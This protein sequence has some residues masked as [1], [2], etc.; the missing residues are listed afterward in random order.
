MLARFSV[1]AQRESS[2]SFAEQLLDALLVLARLVDLGRVLL[3]L[4][5]DDIYLRD[6]FFG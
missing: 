6:N 2:V 3:L 4:P 5:F 1:L